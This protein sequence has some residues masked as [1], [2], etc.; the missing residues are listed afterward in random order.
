MLGA[1]ARLPN[2]KT[3]TVLLVAMFFFD[4]YWALLPSVFI[5]VH[6]FKKSVMVSVAT[7]GGTGETVPMLIRIP[8]FG[9]P[10]GGDRMLGF[11][12]IALPGLLVSY[13]RR[14]DLMSHRKAFEGYFGPSLVGYFTGLCVTIAALTIMKMGQ[15]ALLYLVP[16][17]LGTSI[18]LALCPVLFYP[19]NHIFEPI[20]MDAIGLR[21]FRP[22]DRLDRADASVSADSAPSSASKAPLL[23]VL[24]DCCVAA[25]AFTR[26]L[27]SGPLQAALQRPPG[28]ADRVFSR[29]QVEWLERPSQLQRLAPEG[30]QRLSL[31]VGLEAELKRRLRMSTPVRPKTPKTPARPGTAPTPAR[32]KPRPADS[33]MQCPL[34]AVLRAHCG[35]SW[36]AQLLAQLGLQRQNSVDANSL[37]SALRSLGV[38]SFSSAQVARAI[39]GAKAAE[40]GELR[41]PASAEATVCAIHGPLR[42]ERARAVDDVFFELGGDIHGTL[43]RQTLKRRIAALELPA[44]KAGNSAEEALRN[45]TRRWG[46][47]QEVDRASFSDAHIL[48]SALFRGAKG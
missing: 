6:Q 16:G 48:L 41:G 8:Q 29:L 15:P 10:L 33:P 23:G 12:D 28:E 7:G 9:D 27:C 37:Q 3:A 5:S 2:L 45:F 21:D 46:F 47:K 30:W 13:L 35:E 32:N 18:L 43:T 24:R 25:L 26:A 38:P 4:I 17:T 14:H 1:S 11:G 36:A 22:W 42:G 40:G 39:R 19:L 31:P 44:V 34:R 20:S